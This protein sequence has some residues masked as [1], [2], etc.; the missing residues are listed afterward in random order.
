MVINR[1]RRF[2]VRR[3]GTKR[4]ARVYDWF[5]L[6]KNVAYLGR[7]AEISRQATQRYLH[8]LA[9]VADPRV[10]HKML[11]K[12]CNPVSSPQ[13]RRRALNPLSRAD[14]QFFFAVLR[15][16]HAARG[17]YARDV[18][19]HLNLKATHDPKEKR[20]QSGRVGRRLQLLRAHGLIAKIA[21]T[22][23]YRVTDAGLALMSAAIHLRY[24]AFPEDMAA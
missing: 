23:R 1:P 19:K 11:D 17:F 18:A 20:R 24:K 4:G 13:G 9:A 2:Y 12:V 10:C 6:L 3:W 8:A 5:P 16:E 7:Y 14:Q 15:G 22:R 21:K